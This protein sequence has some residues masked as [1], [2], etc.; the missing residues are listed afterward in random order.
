MIVT[1]V[2]VC[3]CVCV[4]VEYVHSRGVV[5]FSEGR[6]QRFDCNRNGH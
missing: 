2:C 3:V 6:Y 5:R 1:I 4:C